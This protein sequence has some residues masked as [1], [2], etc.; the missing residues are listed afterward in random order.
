MR[1]KIRWKPI[2]PGKDS[3]TVCPRCG[4]LNIQLSS[5]FDAWLMPKRYVCEDCGYVGPLVLEI[6]KEDQKNKKR[7]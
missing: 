5:K 3:V 7:K 4:S 6:D 2:A 1:Q